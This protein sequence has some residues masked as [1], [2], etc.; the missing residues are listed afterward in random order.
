[1]AGGSD[2]DGSGPVVV[3]CVGAIV[4]DRH[5]R[6]LLIRR[7]RPP[8][9]GLW[10]LPGGRVEAGESFPAATAREVLEET[11]LVVEVGVVV[12]TVRR[13]APDGS[14]YDIHDHRATVV[15]GALRAGDDAADA[16]WVD[17]DGYA[18][19]DADGR[20]VPGLTEALA[21]WGCLPG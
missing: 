20:L 9:A 16:A 10:S 5:G 3:P 11:G 12:G 6:L 21:G 8:G 14:V 2:A 13:D 4:H 7:A 18:T 15:G 17:A 1:M 19:L